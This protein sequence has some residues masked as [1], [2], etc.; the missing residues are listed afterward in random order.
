MDGQ[1]LAFKDLTNSSEHISPPVYLLLLVDLFFLLTIATGIPAV[2][3]TAGFTRADHVV[4]HILPTH[5]RV[6]GQAPICFNTDITAEIN[7][8]QFVTM[9]LSKL[10]VLSKAARVGSV[11][12]TAEAPRTPL[13]PQNSDACG[14]VPYVAHTTG[15]N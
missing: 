5:N 11:S 13:A 6:V 8:I 15:M 1:Y 12:A 2:R 3:V 10:T 4:Y 14:V 7:S 9:S